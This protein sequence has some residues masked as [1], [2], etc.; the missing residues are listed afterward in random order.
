MRP[1]ADYG[2]H[3]H[4]LALKQLG[5]STGYIKQSDV[6]TTFAD[7]DVLLGN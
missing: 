4:I 3:I 1:Q 2:T 7:A 6:P 5:N